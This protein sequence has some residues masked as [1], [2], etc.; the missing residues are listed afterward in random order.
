MN[1]YPITCR[2]LLAYSMAFVLLAAAGCNGPA[3][4]H[5][6]ADHG[7]HFNSRT[8]WW[9]FT[10]T[11]TG[12]DGTTLGF[13]CTIFKSQLLGRK[14][15]G[16]IGHV[17][18]SDPAAQEY[19][20][21]ETLTKPPVAGISEGIPRISVTDFSYDFSG[22]RTI[23]IS[24]VSDNA[25][26]NLTLTPREDVLLH[27]RNGAIIMGDGL[28]SYYYSFTNLETSGAISFKGRDYVITSGRTWMDH[29]WG[30]FTAFGE[31]WDW[32]SLRLDDGGALML[33]H[34]RDIFGRTVRTNWTYR[35]AAGDVTYGNLCGVQSHRTYRDPTGACTLPLDWSISIPGLN[36]EFTVRP[37][38]DSQI[39]FSA[40]TPDYWEGLSSVMGSINGAAATGSAYVELTGYCKLLTPDNKTPAESREK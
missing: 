23:S 14:K 13:E 33:F 10:G 3:E 25:S 4:L 18:V 5:F 21:K 19:V 24:A 8:E 28:R 15:F 34:F 32:F 38:F 20:Y 31:L 12:G 1:S 29:Q 22:N 27:G 9:Y 7:P 30:D 2:I 39:F 40:M 17:A 35:S 36:A 37:L 6:P 16:Y 11:A 26:L